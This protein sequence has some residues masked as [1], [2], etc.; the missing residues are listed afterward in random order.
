[1]RTKVLLLTAAIGAVGIASSMAQAVYSV[2]AVG[3]VNTAIPAGGANGAYKMIA[4]PFVTADSRLE[5]L[6]PSPPP[7]TVIYKFAGGT[8]QLTTFDDLDLVWAPANTTLEFGSGAFIRNPAGQAGYNITWVGEVAEGNPVSNPVPPG[9]SIRSSKIPQQGAIQTVLNFVP[10]PGD[11]VYK[12][13]VPLQ[14]FVLYTFDDL[15]LVWAPSEPVL[16]VAESAFILSRAANTVQWNRN[17]DV[18]P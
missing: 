16:D 11:V 12:F 3:Y 13:D 4:N 17:F 10:T 9:F 2:N 7:G 14:T 18:T 15:D 8:F 5:A 6:M 1:M